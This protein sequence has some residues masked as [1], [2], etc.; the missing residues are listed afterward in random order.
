M[1]QSTFQHIQGIG[2][3]TEA[4]LWEKG[5]TDWSQYLRL[6]GKHLSLFKNNDVNPIELSIDAYQKG[7]ISFFG[8][9]LVKSSF[10]RVALSFPEDTLFLDIETT[11]LSLY[12]DQITLV[13]WSTGHLCS[14]AFFQE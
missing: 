5:I 14:T 8:K 2:K 10:Y 11:G 12:Y 1:L 4:L 6:N 9:K 7:D 3:K 13:G